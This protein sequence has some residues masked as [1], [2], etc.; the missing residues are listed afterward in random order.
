MYKV[1]FVDDEIQFRK[2]LHHVIDWEA[3]GFQVC[4]EAKNGLE[5]LELVDKERPD[6]AFIDINMPHMNGMDLAT[7]VKK[8]YPGTFMLFVTGH[9]EFEYARAALKIGVSDYILKPFDKEELIISLTKVK[10]IIE[11]ARLEQDNTKKERLVWK[12][13]FL[14]LLISRECEEEHPQ[15]A[16][17]LE[18][19][20]L[21]G[22]GMRFQVA[23]VE[24]DAMNEPLL[25]SREIRLRQYIVAN[26]LNDIVKPM[27]TMYLFNG[28]ENRVIL[29][30]GYAAEE[31]GQAAFCLDGLRKLCAMIKRHNFGFTVTAGIGTAG[32]GIAAI[33]KSYIESI[34]A[35]RNKISLDFGDVIRYED[36]QSRSSSVG[37]YPH[38]INE[39]LLVQMRQHNEEEVTSNLDAIRQYVE[40]SGLSSDSIHMI[41]AGLVSLCLTYIHE[42]GK[43]PEEVLP[44]DFSPFREIMK[45]SSLDSAFGWIRELYMTVLRQSRSAIRTKSGKTLEQAVAYINEHYADSA[46]KVDDIAKRLFIQ[47]R[48]LLKLFN[49][50]YGKSV[51]DFILDTRMQKAK[52]LLVSGR[53]LRLTDI[54]EMVG[55]GDAG[56]FSKT[57][58][59][60]T[61]ISPSEYEAT[62]TK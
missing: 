25:D 17:Q 22:G 34:I 57:F 11:Q 26:L 40:T 56:H 33:R 50:A 2:Y 4:G 12:E 3:Y 28:P 15:I 62:L 16:E 55:Y 24:I 39:N 58:K 5:A 32:D 47:S 13:S 54:A 1:I 37:F 31:A 44:E 51:S 9:S 6:V 18:L 8:D 35:I 53:N 21:Q 49:Q 59:K 23:S 42:I 14:N 52:E 48:Y 20:R 61:G 10:S 38:E 46:L 30:L 41:L 36:I 7:A 45:H 43:K 19:F 60:Y 29:L 27:S